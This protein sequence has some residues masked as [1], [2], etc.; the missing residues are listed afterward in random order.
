MGP[1][2]L[3]PP[4]NVPAQ[5]QPIP[6]PREVSDTQGLALCLLICPA[7]GWGGRMGPGCQALPWG[8][9][10]APGTPAISQATK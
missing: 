3:D 8:T 6:I 5:P 4:A 2:S 7:P 1:T 9:P 10:P